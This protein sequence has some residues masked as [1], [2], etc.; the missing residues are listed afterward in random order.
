M[1]ISGHP[2]PVAARRTQRQ[3]AL[4]PFGRSIS[5]E[6]TASARACVQARRDRPL[7]G[8]GGL[9]DI[10][11]KT[12]SL[13]GGKRLE[14]ASAACR[15]AAA[16]RW[17]QA[18]AAAGPHGAAGQEAGRAV[19]AADDAFGDQGIE[20]ARPA[21]RP[22]EPIR[23]SAA[24]IT[25]MIAGIRGRRS[26]QVPGR[27][28]HLGADRAQGDRLACPVSRLGDD[29]AAA[30]APGPA[31]ASA[32]FAGQRYPPVQGGAKWLR[33]AQTTGLLPASG[34]KGEAGDQC[35]GQHTAIE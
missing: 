18:G 1:A 24:V 32:G 2:A 31:P 23:R 28:R 17:R 22:A 4:Q 13:L 6:S 26:A 35:R 12:A 21:R 5:S 20:P 33:S 15:R 19:V 11:D 8:S 7:P 10:G 3:Q 27:W 16:R 29:M 25:T 30:T 14:S 34:G 9:F